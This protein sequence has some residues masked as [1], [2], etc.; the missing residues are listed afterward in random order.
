MSV[1]LAANMKREAVDY[2]PF[3]GVNVVRVVPTT[4]PQREVWLAD[5]L[6][7][8]A[9]LAY[10]E[11]VSLTF[12]GALNVEAVCN[13]LQALVQRHESLRA[14]ISAN[15]EELCI[16]SEIAL[17]VPITDYSQLGEDA[18][19]VVVAAARQSAVEK[20]FNLEQGPLFRAELLKLGSEK[21]ILIITAH[22]IV[23]DGWSFGVIVSDLAVLY[24]AAC[25]AESKPLLPADSFADYALQQ[26]ATT[27]T[28]E[29]LADES[30]WLGR[31]S[32]AAPN[33]DLPT[34]RARPAWRTFASKREDYM[35]DADLVS[36]MRMVGASSGASLFAT[37]LGAFITLVYRLSNAEDI[38]I[39]WHN[40]NS[41]R[42]F[43]RI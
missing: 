37:M 18:Q 24:A 10:N 38:V 29:N 9:S 35:L 40:K 12:T 17:H 34:D 23:C 15:G 14:T 6:S 13:A 26:S 41:W 21:Q 3:A 5:Q 2:D 25:G 39:G 43:G 4:E 33:C 30:Y 22:H 8:E 31:F 42:G 1:I 32:G 7:L 20:P 27:G 11:S 16:L 36:A 19:A 28:T